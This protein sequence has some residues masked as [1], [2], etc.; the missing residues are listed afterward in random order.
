MNE[1]V[2]AKI[3]ESKIENAKFD[4]LSD[5]SEEINKA[6]VEKNRDKFNHY[7]QLLNT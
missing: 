2:M 6:A 7:F 4:I 3:S 5:I 1:D